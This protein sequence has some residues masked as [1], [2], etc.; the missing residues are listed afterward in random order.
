M[1]SFDDTYF[2]V[3]AISE[4]PPYEVVGM[5]DVGSTRPPLA[6]KTKRIK[7]VKEVPPQD[8]ATDRFVKF[9]Q[10]A[11][12][13][14]AAGVISTALVS[15]GGSGGSSGKLRPI[16]IAC[17][18]V[19]LGALYAGVLYFLY[20]RIAALEKSLRESTQEIQKLT[21]LMES[22]EEIADVQLP[23][24]VAPAL[25]SMPKAR[26][27]KATVYAEEYDE[28]GE[29]EEEEEEEDAYGDD[30][31]EE[32]EEE[33]EEEDV[34]LP[35]VQE[36]PTPPRPTR[37]VAA[38]VPPPPVSSRK[39]SGKKPKAV[40]AKKPP[41]VVLDLDAAAESGTTNDPTTTPLPS[42]P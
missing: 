22:D 8:H 3:D 10:A 31:D 37:R 19:G 20:K 30:D 1:D 18:A 27:E 7:K 16:L 34:Y 38:P 35:K 5:E 42:S 26:V 36:L 23:F 29:E 17:A 25:K 33:E 6:R 2:K 4:S 14:A 15:K 9:Q 32:E 21:R 11:T 24:Q 28:E 12:G 13:A 39:N 41:V 40:A